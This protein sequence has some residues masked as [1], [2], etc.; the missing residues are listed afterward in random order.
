MAGNKFKEFLFKG[1]DGKNAIDNVKD[2]IKGNKPIM[3][4]KS[5]EEKADLNKNLTKAQE[6]RAAETQR[7][8]TTQTAVKEKIAPE[9]AAKKTGEN[10][11][12][13]Q[14]KI[15][16]P[17]DV[18]EKA[19]AAI[20]AFDDNEKTEIENEIASVSGEAAPETPEQAKET[21]LD[22]AKKQGLVTIDENGKI[23]FAKLKMTPKSVI[24]K[25]GSVL[26]AL[27]TMA[28]GGAIPPINFYKLSNAEQEDQARIKLYDDLM[29]NIAAEKGAVESDKVRAEQDKKTA[30]AAGENRFAADKE[31]AR[32]QQAL[33]NEMQRLAY[34]TNQQKDLANFMAKV[35]AKKVPYMYE[36]MRESGM[37]EKQIRD[38][39]RAYA[40]SLPGWTEYLKLGTGVAKDV[41]GVVGGLVK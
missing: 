27:L 36:A 5:E 30:E 25:I 37:T 40:G 10:M 11:K 22:Y 7:L 9:E 35:D 8:A 13:T 2:W 31:K 17:N 15:T 18:T 29:N 1:E 21:L 23:D 41:A 33:D 32:M 14:E 20:K 19:D 26:S 6:G 12:E 16:A 4:A 24:S 34:S 39:V 3:E 28:S 38:T